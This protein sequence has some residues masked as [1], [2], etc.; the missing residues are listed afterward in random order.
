MAIFSNEFPTDFEPGSDFV[1]IEDEEF[2]LASEPGGLI[3]IQI[4]N[5]LG[6]LTLNA[7]KRLL[8]SLAVAITNSETNGDKWSDER[9][10]ER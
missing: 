1:Q 10:D 8:S 7:A 5:D 3:A 2:A 6:Y 4:D 9:H